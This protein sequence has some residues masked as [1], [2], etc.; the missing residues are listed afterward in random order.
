MGQTSRRYSSG[1]GD[2]SSRSADYGGGYGG[3]N[4]SGYG[5]GY[6]TSP[7]PEAPAEDK[8]TRSRLITFAVAVALVSFFC[9]YALRDIFSSEGGF[10][11][12]RP[13]QAEQ[14]PPNLRGFCV[15]YD[16]YP[17]FTLVTVASTSALTATTVPVVKLD[18]CTIPTRQTANALQALG[19]DRRAES[20][21][22]QLGGSNLTLVNFPL[23]DALA[24]Q[25]IA[26]YPILADSLDG[27]S[28]EAKEATLENALYEML[29]GGAGGLSLQN[30]IKTNQPGVYAIAPGHT[31]NLQ[32]QLQPSSVPR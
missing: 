32:P 22:L 23:T 20:I 3:G 30:V 9:G 29:Q 5:G 8:R 6:G 7:S 17:S 24:T 26:R 18:T 10:D 4:G 16:G 21:G 25:L 1:Y 27:S 19:V 14:V 28:R 12:E 15:S 11:D 2:R 13:I 31:F